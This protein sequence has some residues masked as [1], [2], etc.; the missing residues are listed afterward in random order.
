[1][2][3]YTGFN[4]GM[5]NISITEIDFYVDPIMVDFDGMS[6]TSELITKFINFIVNAGRSRLISV[7]QTKMFDSFHKLN[8]LINTII[9]LIP[10]EISIPGTDI[11]T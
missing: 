7:T 2:T 5:L 6:D 10:Y 3:A 1:M 8:L 9:G 4:H 11:F